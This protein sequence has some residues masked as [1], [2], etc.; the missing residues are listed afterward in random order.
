MEDPMTKDA[1]DGM[2]ER[3]LN[4]GAG[5]ILDWMRDCE[6]PFTCKA[7]SR[8]EWVEEPGKRPYKRIIGSFCACTPPLDAAIA[9]GKEKEDG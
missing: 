4:D 6:S 7:Y 8:T 9:V 3:K 1:E 5:S 2:V